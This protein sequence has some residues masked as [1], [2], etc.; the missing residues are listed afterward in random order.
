VGSPVA[1][2]LDAAAPPVRRTRDL[3]DRMSLADKV[4]QLVC[5]PLDPAGPEP[6]PAGLLEV[7]GDDPDRVAAAVRAAQVRL[8][9]DTALGIPALPVMAAPL[10]G[11]PAFPPPLGL[12]AGWDTELVARVAAAQARQAR[13]LGVRLLVG[14]A[15]GAGGSVHG[16]GGDPLLAAEL[17][18]AH[19]HGVQAGGDVG[20]LAIDL[21]ATADARSGER[22][23]RSRV[24]PPARAAVLAGVA[25]VAPAA[26]ANAGV[27]AHADP[28]LLR[29]LLR[30]EWGF[31]GA[32]LGDPAAVA[33]LHTRYRVAGSVDDALALALESGVDGIRGPA[34]DTAD[35]L[36]RLVGRG[37]LPEW[38]LDDAVAA[39]L[40]LKFRLGLF[41]D[42]FPRAIPPDPVRDLL[43]ATVAGSAVLL[44][45]PR[46]LLP[47]R[48]GRCTVLAA[49]DPRDPA[50]A[51]A[52]ALQPRLAGTRRAAADDPVVV[53][54]ATA[55]RAA[56][57]V[58]RVAAGRRPCVVL[59]CGPALG[60]LEFVLATLSGVLWCCGAGPAV[61]DRVA[62]L[63]TGS[64]TPSGRLPV[65]SGPA[66]PLGHGRSYSAFEYTDLRVGPRRARP[67]E[68]VQ[69]SCRVQ[70]TGALPGREV[71]QVYA[72]DRVGSVVRPEQVLVGFSSVGL[73]AGE[74]REV[75]LLL[76]ADRFALWD[77]GMRRVVEPGVFDVL[78]GRSARDVLLATEL[79][80]LPDDDPGGVS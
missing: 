28:W 19:V 68:T 37:A 29:T 7:T 53:V 58:A 51:L 32:V 13:A 48:R 20:C 49:S 56:A 65:P 1:P 52:A 45:D 23:L 2:Y 77:R 14:P 59:L 6:G 70:N 35:R 27:P 36:L 34:G 3:M 66:V 16:F 80:V 74:G 8:V 25:A 60:G 76:P 54:A 43:D 9:Q 38:Q 69:V 17:I 21:G 40:A 12:A 50:A 72:R 39:V 63:L 31:H 57:E 5:A 62:D 64:R 30:G 55:D 42:P 26:T 11:Q 4:V 78:V 79:V 46:R 41:E 18:E 73:A 47:L 71:V 15:L 24:L 33:E 67:G 22:L 44:A 10:P 61:A 75:R